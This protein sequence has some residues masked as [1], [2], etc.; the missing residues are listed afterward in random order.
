M[1]GKEETDQPVPVHLMSMRVG[2]NVASNR[3]IVCEQMG[4]SIKPLLNITR[5][6]VGR[7]VEREGDVGGFIR[8]RGE[9]A[10]LRIPE[11]MHQGSLNENGFVTKVTMPR[12]AVSSSRGS[13][14]PGKMG[15]E[16]RDL[17]KKEREGGRV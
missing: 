13:G 11:G 9:E 2:K 10:L 14:G 4:N 5:V 6:E 8:N 1:V 12:G 17:V 7:I 15:I 3:G 16:V